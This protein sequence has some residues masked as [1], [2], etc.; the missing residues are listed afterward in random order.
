M[1][2]GLDRLEQALRWGRM[3]RRLAEGLLERETLLDPRI[4]PGPASRRPVG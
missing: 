3:A 2:N 4:R 1:A